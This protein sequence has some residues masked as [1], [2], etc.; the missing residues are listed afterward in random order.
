MGTQPTSRAK[1]PGART[2][3]PVKP[4]WLT[5]RAPGGPR[6]NRVAARMRD[7]H[8]N[9]VCE[10]AHCPNIGECWGGGTATVM[11]MGDTCTRGCRFCAVKSGHPAALDPDEP[12][13]AAEAIAS[14]DVDYVVLTSVDRDELPD[15]GAGHFAATI[16]ALREVAPKVMVEVLVGDFQG[17]PAAL[18]QIV[19]AG[20][21]V[22]AHN[23]EV[24]ARLQRTARDHRASYEQSLQVLRRAAEWG[25]GRAPA[26]ADIAAKTS[27]MVGLGERED[28]VL[29]ALRDV[30]ATGCE[31]VT[32]GQYLQ[33]SRKHLPVEEYVPPERFDAY[34]RAARELGFLYVA[35]G[36]L[37]RSSYRAGELFIRGHL[38]RRA[39]GSEAAKRA[40]G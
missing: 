27:L 40:N 1:D 35:S 36:P 6:F 32:L 15:G 16:R 20:P 12:K 7:L 30:R 4:R 37:V 8:L 33:P 18:Q 29:Q 17:D 31:I 3:R 2:P 21:E 24:V 39:G 10:E 25:R 9:T 38:E 22:L 26:G 34:A 28:E 13:N 14:L 5:V 19:D 23:V 11:L